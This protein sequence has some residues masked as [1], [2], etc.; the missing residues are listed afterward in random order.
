MNGVERIRKEVVQVQQDLLTPM[1]FLAAVEFDQLQG[2]DADA[3]LER[4]HDLLVAASV[5]LGLQAERIETLRRQ[6]HEVR[7]AAAAHG[8]AVSS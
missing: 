3:M 4:A 6:N 8:E 2:E 7:I 5:T 1:N